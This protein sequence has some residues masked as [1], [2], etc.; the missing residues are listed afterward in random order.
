MDH[1]SGAVR[2][3]CDIQVDGRLGPGRPKM[4]WKKLMEKD[5]RERKFMTVDHQKR[6]TLR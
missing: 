2:T 5:C 3:A 6:D 1:S 4:T